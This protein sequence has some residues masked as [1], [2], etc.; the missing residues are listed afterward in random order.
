MIDPTLL[1]NA[2]KSSISPTAQIIGFDLKIEPSHIAYVMQMMLSQDAYRSDLENLLKKCLGRDAILS[3]A[4]NPA[5]YG[6]NDSNNPS[7]SVQFGYGIFTIFGASGAQGGAGSS[8]ISVSNKLLLE[9]Y[10]S[11]YFPQAYS[12][13]APAETKP[14]IQYLQGRFYLYGNH[15]ADER[16]DR[17]IYIIL[18]RT[19]IGDSIIN[20]IQTAIEAMPIF[21]M[22]NYSLKQEDWRGK[23]PPQVDL[24]IPSDLA[25]FY[26]SFLKCFYAIVIK[27]YKDIMP[28]EYATW[29]QMMGDKA[30][31]AIPENIGVGLPKQTKASSN[32]L[33]WLIGGA[34]WS[35]AVIK[36]KKG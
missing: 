18:E 17:F 14:G 29:A 16:I 36:K 9:K 28:D 13:G 7:I 32:I 35:F 10:W 26:T 25:G 34:L 20:A 6:L 8:N 24:M 21:G 2:L 22:V 27:F 12:V 4:G 15:H 31:T 19:K 5:D 30:L 33:P 11:D 1:Q 23:L 3:L